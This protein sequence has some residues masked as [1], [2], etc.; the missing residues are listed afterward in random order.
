MPKLPSS[1][2]DVSTTIIP[3]P[4]GSYNLEVDEVTV[5]KSKSQLDMIT[6]TYKLLDNEEFPNRTIR[7]YFVLETKKHE[8]NESGLR[9]FKRL[10]VAALG[11][12]RA[13]AEDFDTDELKGATITA[14]IKQEQYED[15][16]TGEEMVSNR[17]KKIIPSA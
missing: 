1:L 12:E 13:D 5:G 4:E 2:A 6:V 15:E 17:I 9:G 11:E 16:D 3:L 7:D 8:P 10:V 14:I